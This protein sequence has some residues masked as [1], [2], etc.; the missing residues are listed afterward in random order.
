MIFR[1]RSSNIGY[2]LSVVSYQLSVVGG[3]FLHEFPL[4]LC[5]SV[6]LCL[7]RTQVP[8]TKQELYNCLENTGDMIH[9]CLNFFLSIDSSN[10]FFRGNEL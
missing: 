3:Q 7:L 10:P 2:Q 6:P 5:A 4:R 9:K 1:K 8:Y